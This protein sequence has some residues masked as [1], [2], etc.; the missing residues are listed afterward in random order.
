MSTLSK[1]SDHLFAQLDR[2]GD[3]SLTPDQIESEAQRADAI[4]KIS[5]EIIDG[6]KTQIAAARLYGEHG[7][8]VLP[9][10]PQIGAP[11]KD[12]ERDE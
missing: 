8:H 6:A 3:D 5:D 7:Q 10:L 1:L 12:D 4:V 11:R 2:L 9:M